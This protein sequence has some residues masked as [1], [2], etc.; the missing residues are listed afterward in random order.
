MTLCHLSTTTS[1]HVHT[2][3]TCLS[4]VCVSVLGMTQNC[5]HLWGSSSKECGVTSS[6]PLLPGQI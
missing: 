4:L 1:A 6:L 5:I 3:T 2:K